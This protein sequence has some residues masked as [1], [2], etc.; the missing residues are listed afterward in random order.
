V[1]TAAITQS[2]SVAP[3]PSAPVAEKPAEKPVAPEKPVVAEKPAASEP[4]VASSDKFGMLDTSG[5]PGD[6]R[7]WVNDKLV[8]QT[9][10]NVKAPCGLHAVKIGSGGTPHDVMIP[11][12]G[13]VAVK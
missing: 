2:A 12:G 11:C 3:V 13:T 4:A 8:G 1:V 7:I 10:G 9:G 5:A 6:R